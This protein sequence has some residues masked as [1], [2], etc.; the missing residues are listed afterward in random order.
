MSLSSRQEVRELR[1]VD[2]RYESNRFARQRDTTEIR[3]SVADR[4]N[5]ALQDSELNAKYEN[6]R[7]YVEMMCEKCY[8]Q[9]RDALVPSA[10]S[11][12]ELQ[13]AHGFGLSVEDVQAI[14]Q[15]IEQQLQQ[16]QDINNRGLTAQLDKYTDD[17]SDDDVVL[18]DSAAVVDAD[19][20]GDAKNVRLFRELSPAMRRFL[21]ARSN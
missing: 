18:I 12:N 17:G 2:Y 16:H 10:N 3:S 21:L 13:D 6:S 19:A 4:T 9:R 7:I 15:E 1:T 11:P 8:L 14:R 20:E 5:C